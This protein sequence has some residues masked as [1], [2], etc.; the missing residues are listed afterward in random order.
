LP[1]E[2][3]WE[4]A[5]RA[6][7]ATRFS[8]GDDESALADYGWFGGNVGGEQYAHGVGQK[9]ANPWGLYDM[10]GNVGEWCRDWYEATLSG[11]NDPERSVGGSSR[12]L[13]GGGWVGPA[14]HCRSAIR[15]KRPPANRDPYLG[16]RVALNPSGK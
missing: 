7:T 3:Q 11:G 12:V 13:R 2:A 8:F 9:R 15:G 1:T 5:C 16:F 4:Y 6:G 10:H 14:R